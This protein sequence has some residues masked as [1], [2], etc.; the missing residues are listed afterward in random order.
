MDVRNGFWAIA[1]AALATACALEGEPRPVS[2]VPVLAPVVESGAV[3]PAPTA[4]RPRHKVFTTG[5]Q[6]QR[7]REM[8]ARWQQRRYTELLAALGT[9]KRVMA[10]P[11]GGNPPSFAVVYGLDAVSGCVD[12]FA[13]SMEDDPKVRIYHCR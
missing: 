9:P 3:A 7:E 11:G 13:I 10:I 5:P 4:R 2:P 6:S 8:N 12:A 1:T